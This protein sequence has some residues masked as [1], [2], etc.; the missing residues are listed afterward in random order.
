MARGFR[1]AEPEVTSASEVA[2]ARP[3]SSSGTS[4]GGAGGAKG[5]PFL[6]RLG[7]LRRVRSGRLMLDAVD[8]AGESMAAGAGALGIRLHR[9]VTR[10]RDLD[11][12]EAGG[13]VV[14]GSGAGAVWRRAGS[15]LMRFGSGRLATRGSTVVVGAEEGEG[16]GRGKGKDEGKG[17]LT[18]AE[19]SDGK[20]AVGGEGALPVCVVVK[21]GDEWSGQGSS[22]ASASYSSG[23]PSEAGAGPGGEGKGLGAVSAGAG[24]GIGGAVFAIGEQEGEQEEGVAGPQFRLGAILLRVSRGLCHAT[25]RVRHRVGPAG[26]RSQGRGRGVRRP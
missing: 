24:A 18:G 1:W 12:Q 3:G 7:S 4:G 6:R 21:V 8:A 16:E 5:G 17:L 26:E 15:L 22:S 10:T 23:P 11:A 2:G 25:G 9:A 19:K 13:A 14:G 20:V